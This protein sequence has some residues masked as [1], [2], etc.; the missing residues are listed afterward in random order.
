LEPL[1]YRD[2]DLPELPSEL[3][4]LFEWSIVCAM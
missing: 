3:W 4:Q 2:A 1:V